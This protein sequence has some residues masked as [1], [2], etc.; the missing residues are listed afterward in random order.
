M[1]GG[2]LAPAENQPLLL[3]LRSLPAGKTT[4]PLADA[5]FLLIPGARSGSRKASD[6][7]L[8]RDTCKCLILNGAP[9]AI[10]TRGLQIRSPV[11]L[12]EMRYLKLMRS[13]EMA[14]KGLLST[15]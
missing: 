3:S 9:G 14:H 4:P 15:D 2:L 5:L 13:F 10:R 1:A 6:G 8:A 7:V 11:V 12:L